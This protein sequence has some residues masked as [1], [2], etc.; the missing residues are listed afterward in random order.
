VRR[1]R[2]AVIAGVAGVAAGCGLGGAGLGLPAAASAHAARPTPAHLL[3]YA[4]EW[5]LWPSRTTLPAGTVDVQLWNRGQDAH[6]VRVRRR[7]AQGVM[8][9]AV[10]GGVSVTPSGDIHSAVWHLKAG[11]Y[12]IYC[13]LPG[14]LMMGMH[15]NLTVTGR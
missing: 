7:N 12:E 13:S 10:L 6:D 8:V 11:R 1:L 2:Q 14:H 9:G 3:V 4:Q 15:A 5:S